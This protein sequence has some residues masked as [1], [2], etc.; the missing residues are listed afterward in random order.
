MHNKL[1]T[2]LIVLS[3]ILLIS[4]PIMN[5][6]LQLVKDI[7]ETENRKMAEKPVMVY[8][9][10]DAFPKQ[11]EKYYNDN[12]TIRSIMVKYYNLINLEFFK[13][14][15]VPDQV[16]IGKDKWLFMAGKDLDCY[17]GL[18][19][20]DQS[21]LEAI[22]EE[23]EYRKKYLEKRGCKFYF[24][25]APSKAS[26]YPEKMP[27]GIFRF[28]KQSWGEQLIEY[29]QAN[30]DVKPIDLFNVLRAQKDNELNYF[31]LDN[32][33]TQLGAF[34]A[35]NEILKRFRE[36]FPGI[37]LTTLEDYNIERTEI[38][39]G[40]ILAMISN[41][42]NFSDY[43]YRLTPKSGF[44]AQNVKPVGYPVIKGFP[45]PWEYESDK[46]IK[47]SEKPKIL[48]IS[49]SFGSYL[50][51]FLAEDFRRSVK[52]FD[53]WQFKLNEDIVQSEKPD[54]FLLV[55][56]ESIIRS[57]LNFQSRLIPEQKSP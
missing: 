9:H 41:I 38:K 25:I 53:S 4:F 7:A 3:F 20:F 8:T 34:Y 28:S 52:I 35:G 50:F 37:A 12:F 24:V 42:G 10:L 27:D 49:D 46:E 33:W 6:H 31:K 18:H 5:S 51:P 29:L 2:Y 11:Y 14:S 48:I 17:A 32:H 39:T 15:P 54:I 30:C 45:Y 44:L 19:R 43:S 40:N 1:R 23:L 21:E 56:S 36:E 26:I 57:M 22:K 55:V 16:V 47:G 13:K